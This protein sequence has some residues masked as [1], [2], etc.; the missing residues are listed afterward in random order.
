MGAANK[1]TA[2]GGDLFRSQ[3]LLLV[4]N[5]LGNHG[6]QYYSILTSLSS[7]HTSISKIELVLYFGNTPVMVKLIQCDCY[8]INLCCKL[9]T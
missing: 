8:V 7:G 9:L 3:V 2:S 4:E 6:M 1:W 5:G